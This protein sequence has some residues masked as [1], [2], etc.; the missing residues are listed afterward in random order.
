MWRSAFLCVLRLWFSWPN[1][2][3]ILISLQCVLSTCDLNESHSKL[4]YL[5]EFIHTEL[6]QKSRGINL[7]F[8]YFSQKALKRY[9]H[10]L[11]KVWSFSREN[12]FHTRR[13]KKNVWEG[14]WR[15][16]S[17]RDYIM[18]RIDGNVITDMTLTQS[19]QIC[20]NYQRV[21]GYV[22]QSLSEEVSFQALRQAYPTRNTAPNPTTTVSRERMKWN[23]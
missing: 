1:T 10:D 15:R 9:Q 12:D 20:K 21:G 11:D 17:G 16:V 23:K 2:K 7:E 5:F 4:E 14:S 8:R 22:D 18:A 6:L 3:G 19:G 13:R